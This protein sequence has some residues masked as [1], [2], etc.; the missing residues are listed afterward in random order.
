MLFSALNLKIPRL[1]KN[2]RGMY[3]VRQSAP[4]ALG[5][6]KVVQH[7]LATKD[8]NTAKYLAL[9]FNLTL[10]EGLSVTDFLIFAPT[11]LLT[12]FLGKLLPTGSKITPEPW[13]LEL[14]STSNGWSKMQLKF[15]WP[16]FGLQAL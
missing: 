11:K 1:G 8:P 6:R 2:R 15:D 10:A 4:D 16:P 12:Q 13:K 9:K 14:L 5:T 7:S 3:Y